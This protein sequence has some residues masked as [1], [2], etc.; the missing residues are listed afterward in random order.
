MGHPPSHQVT[1]RCSPASAGHWLPEIRQHYFLISPMS[2]QS[3]NDVHKSPLYGRH[4]IHSLSFQRLGLSKILAEALTALVCV[5]LTRLVVTH[6]G[7]AVLTVGQV[8]R[9]KPVMWSGHLSQPVAWEVG[10]TQ[11][12]RAGGRRQIWWIKKDPP[13][14]RTGLQ[15][16]RVQGTW[17]LTVCCQEGRESVLSGSCWACVL[18]PQTGAKWGAGGRGDLRAWVEARSN[19]A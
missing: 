9:G 6:A 14:V 5:P 12:G 17:H 4:L 2:C 1:L 16:Q 13:V 19:M 15:G 3:S 8:E 11:Q 10:C 7:L 18:E